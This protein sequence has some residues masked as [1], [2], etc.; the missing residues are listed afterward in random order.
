MANQTFQR[1]NVYKD[2]DLSFGMNPL[3]KDIGVKTDVNA[4]IQ[5]VKNLINTNFY[6]RAFEP[7]IGC[8]VRGLLFEPADP[9]TMV[10]LRS[11][12][13]QTL[14]NYEPRIEVAEIQLTDQTDSNSY[15]I[16][17]IFKIKNNSSV[18][19]VNITLKR[20]R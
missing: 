16:H 11:A 13:L 15:N 3:T 10:D 19:D 5:S 14:S 4:I 8:N 1:K 17:L 20:L 7:T 9:I 2:F 6:E 12:I 18:Q